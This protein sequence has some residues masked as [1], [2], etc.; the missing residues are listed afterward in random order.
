MNLDLH[1]PYDRRMDIEVFDILGN[2][3]D[4]ISDHRIYTRGTHTIHWSPKHN[5]SGV[6]YIRL[7]DG[8]DSEFKKIMLIK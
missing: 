1:I 2:E 8:M 6:Y 7:T 4:I 3:I 5:A